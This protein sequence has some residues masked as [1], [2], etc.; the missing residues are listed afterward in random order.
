MVVFS[1]RPQEKLSFL[2]KQKEFSI[3]FSEFAK[4]GNF[5]LNL[6]QIVSEKVGIG[7]PPRIS[8]LLVK[9]CTKTQN[10]L[11]SF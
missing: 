7:Q 9:S 8:A 11:K 1:H 3:V 5:Q 2:S 6:S 4:T 10:L